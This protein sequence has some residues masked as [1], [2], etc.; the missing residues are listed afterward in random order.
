[1][2]AQIREASQKL[3]ERKKSKIRASQGRDQETVKKRKKT[4]SHRVARKKGGYSP[5]LNTKNGKCGKI[6]HSYKE[7]GKESKRIYWF[8]LFP[9]EREESSQKKKAW[10]EGFVFRKKAKEGE[11]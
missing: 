1:V 7:G 3:G 10:D 4:L 9:K 11:G 8:M 6:S 2:N 5:V